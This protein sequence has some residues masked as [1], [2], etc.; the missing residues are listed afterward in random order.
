MQV[1]GLC[2]F[3][4]PAVGGFQ[5]NHDTLEERIAFLYDPARIEPR[6]DVFHRITL[7]PLRAQTDPDFKLVVVT[8]KAMPNRYM[9]HLRGMLRDVPQAEIVTPE[10][11]RH[12]NVMRRMLNAAKTSLSGQMA[13]FRMDDDDAVAVDF[14][15]EVR[16]Q[17]QA[18][19]GPLPYA[20]DF[21]KGYVIAPDPEAP[22]V[23]AVTEPHW[24]PA[25][26][27]ISDASLPRAITNYAHH[28]IHQRLPMTY[29]DEKPMFLRGL[30][31]Q[32]DS[33][34]W[35]GALQPSAPSDQDRRI[36]RDRFALDL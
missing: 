3:S 9:R 27:V 29:I 8:G 2:R 10:A 1:I 20:L 22:L 34:S 13:Q 26:A 28:K 21:T 5:I 25:L 4:Y 19:A 15:A 14:V 35:K 18:V 12:R 31:D 32:N 7:P 24:T 36:L 23:Q 6:L 33:V 11:G 30:T 16:K 17:A